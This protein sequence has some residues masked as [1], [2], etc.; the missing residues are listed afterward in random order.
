MPAV[1]AFSKSATDVKHVG[2]QATHMSGFVG[3]LIS[4]FHVS[5]VS[6]SSSNSPKSR[7]KYSCLWLNT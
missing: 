7:S 6:S 2:K 5:A 4:S 1:V 3:S